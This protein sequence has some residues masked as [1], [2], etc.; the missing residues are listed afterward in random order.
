MRNWLVF[1]GCILLA[2]GAGLIGTLATTPAIGGWYATL[3]RP[4]IAPPNWV[5]GPVWTTL[6]FLMGV[7]LFL[8]WRRGGTAVAYV[9]F[10]FQL[11]LN[12]LWSFIFFGA[13]NLGGALIEIALLWIAIAATI[14]AFAKKSKTAAWLLVP[15][16]LWV[17]FASYLN[18]MFW[19]LNS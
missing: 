16:L 17:S 18:F 8:V 6:F 2:E 11:A 9:A 19:T 3:I 5:F 7:A 15:Y 14:W 1:I 13:H 12:I 4:D 10:G